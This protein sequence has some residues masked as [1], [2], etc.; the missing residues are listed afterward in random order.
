MEDINRDRKDTVKMKESKRMKWYMRERDKIRK[1]KGW[2]DLIEWDN[3]NDRER[4]KGW[5]ERRKW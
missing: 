3:E 2:S 5:C 4:K 1:K